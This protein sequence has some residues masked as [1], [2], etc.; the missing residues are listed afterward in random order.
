MRIILLSFIFLQFNSNLFAQTH[1]HKKWVLMSI[2]NLSTGIKKQVGESVIA[3]LIF[4]NDTTY[5]GSFCNDYK[6][7]AKFN[8]DLTCSFSVPSST[9][10]R[11]MGIDD[12]E[13]ELFRLY[14]LVTRYKLKNHLLY[15]FT[16]DQKRLVFKS[17][18]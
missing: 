9:N 7:K 1:L 18:E 10:R 16:S 17:E 13:K 11:C 8:A 2:D 3:D 6:G 14:T 15:L 5:K 12:V 4:D